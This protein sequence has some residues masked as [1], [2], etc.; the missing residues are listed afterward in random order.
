MSLVLS[1][2]AFVLESVKDGK[3]YQFVV[4]ME[5]RPGALAAAVSLVAKNN[6]TA[7]SGFHYVDPKN[8][9]E[10]WSFFADFSKAAVTPEQVCSE[11]SKDSVVK[12]AEY[13]RSEFQDLAVDE[14]HF[15]IVTGD[16]DRAVFLREATFGAAI[17]KL[18]NVFGPG[19]GTILW[20]MGR[21]AGDFEAKRVRERLRLNQVDALKYLLADKRASGWYIGQIEE[22]ATSP[23]KLI[24]KVEHSIECE[25]RSS[26]HREPMGFFLKG[27]LNGYIS[28]ILEKEL[29][30]KELKCRAKGD[31]FCEFQLTE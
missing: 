24:A 1:K 21:A 22:V 18:W 14:V 8:N 20:E 5:N 3:L 25:H 31:S 23:V 28:F 30:I 11:L 17:E 16:G 6:L 15:P 4:L 13:R 10:E 29:K 27:Y 9:W 2:K 19:A 26:K 12:R 7:L